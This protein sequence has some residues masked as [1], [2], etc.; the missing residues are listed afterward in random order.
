MIFF[1]YSRFIS[2][3]ID[4]HVHISTCLLFRRGRFRAAIRFQC[5]LG[6]EEEADEENVL[7]EEAEDFLQDKIDW[8]ALEALAFLKTLVKML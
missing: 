1:V 6:S 8:R 3:Y 7:P 5:E 2:L 4:T